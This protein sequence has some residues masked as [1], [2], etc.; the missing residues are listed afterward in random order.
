MRDRRRLTGGKVGDTSSDLQQGLVSG[1]AKVIGA[2]Y[3]THRTEER[4]RSRRVGVRTVEEHRAQL[5]KKTAAEYPSSVAESV[6]VRS[7][8]IPA[9]RPSTAWLQVPAGRATVWG[10]GRWLK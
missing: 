3:V 4:A 2:A 6:A 5:L 7:A 8:S 9:A 10:E 1:C